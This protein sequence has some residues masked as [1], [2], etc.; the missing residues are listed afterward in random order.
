[1]S[2]LKNYIFQQSY[3]TELKD[4][5]NSHYIYPKTKSTKEPVNKTTIDQKGGRKTIQ[6]QTTQ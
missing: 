5:I 3:R 1:M 2:E 4:T 6:V